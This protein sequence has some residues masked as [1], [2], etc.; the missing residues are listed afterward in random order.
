[1]TTQ[2]LDVCLIGAGP[3]GLSVLERLCANAPEAA[4]T[5]SVTV[6]VVDPYPPGAGRV[7]RSD[8]HRHLLM[9]TVA[10]QVTLFTDETVE[11]AG[12]VLP[13]P[14]LYEWARFVSLTGGLDEVGCEVGYGEDVLAEARRLG[15]DSYPTRAFHG[16]YL[17]WVHRRVTGTAPASVR[18]VSHRSRAVG[19]EERTAGGAQTVVLE[20]GTR[21]AGLHAVVLAQGHLPQR[22][23]PREA[24]HAAFAE[25]RGLRY[26]PPANPAEVDLSGVRPGEAVGLLGLGLSFFDYLAL[27]TEGRDGRFERRA[28]RLVYRPSG[29]EPRLLAGSRR[30]VPFHSRGENQK[31][32]HGRHHPLVLTPE[33][34][35]GLRRRARE[36]GG[37]D[38]R[39]ELWPLISKEVETVYYTA[40]LTARGREAAAHRLRAAYPSAPGG[41]AAE[42]RLLTESG[43]PLRERW[44]WSRIARPCPADGL[45][46]PAAFRSWLLGY[47]RADLEAARAGNVQ[48]PLKAALDVLRDLRNEIRL[49][50]DHGGL[51]ARS[52]RED[53]DAWYTPLNAF[54]SIGPPA[55]RIEEAVALIEAGVL[56]VLGPRTVA[57]ADSEEGAFVLESRAVPGSRRR[58]TTLIDARLPGTDVRSS[59]DPLLSG[60]LTSGQC[61]PYA[62]GGAGNGTGNGNGPGGLETGG[63]A[64]GPSPYHL[65]DGA[66]RPHPRRFAFGVPTESVHWATAAGVRPGVGSVIL[67]DADAISRAVLALRDGSPTDPNGPTGPETIEVSVP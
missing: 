26:L 14:S 33:V 60:L 65:L 1:M 20:D 62:V 7:W 27:L 57:R 9:N 25:A 17:E 3:R 5:T 6:H 39:S 22:R 24:A 23:S 35:R 40:L 49:V 59:A 58:A 36:R 15:P 55:R 37:L 66:G 61:G 48:G 63:L 47:L 34:I 10:G 52:H 12:P 51:T 67:S 29:R 50:V 13:G 53:L 31:G 4:P 21:L 56:T 43:I 30:G 54:V 42:D 11:M 28:G 45:R 32:P 64:V 18:T 44:N 8:Q 46:S 19:L 41:S 38:F 16:H 2:R